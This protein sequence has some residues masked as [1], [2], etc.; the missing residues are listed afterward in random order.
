MVERF[1]Y[2]GGSCLRTKREV[3]KVLTVFYCMEE[4][5]LPN[6]RWLLMIDLVLLSLVRQFKWA[7]AANKNYAALVDTL[8]GVA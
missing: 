6:Y 5:Y 3:C 4:K 1:T 7:V 2:F 8:Q